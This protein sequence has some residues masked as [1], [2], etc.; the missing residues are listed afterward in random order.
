MFQNGRRILR[1]QLQKTEPTG[2][3]PKKAMPDR[4]PYVKWYQVKITTE[5]NIITA[6]NEHPFSEDSRFTSYSY[7]TKDCTATE[8]HATAE[9]PRIQHVAS[10]EETEVLT[11]AQI[12]VTKNKPETQESLHSYFF[13]NFY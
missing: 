4:R 11:L 8:L 12:S 9:R 5:T 2:V 13:L 1:F 6:A 3:L 10:S 7:R